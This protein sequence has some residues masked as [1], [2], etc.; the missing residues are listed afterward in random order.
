MQEAQKARQ[1]LA[2]TKKALGDLAGALALEQK[3]FA[4]RSK[5]LP[6]EHPDLQKARGN[7][8]GTKSALGDLAGASDNRA[9]VSIAC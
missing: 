1:N 6:D 4:V 8:A 5:T 2:M 7:L 3:V 9:E